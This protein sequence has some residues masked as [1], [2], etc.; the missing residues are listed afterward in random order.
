MAATASHADTVDARCELVPQG[1]KIAKQITSC[2][3]SQR[4]GYISLQ[5]PQGTRYDFSPQ[6]RPGRYSDQ[7]GELVVRQSG[8]GQR[9]MLFRMKAHM[10]Y[11]YWTTAAKMLLTPPEATA[12]FAEQFSWGSIRFQVES[13]NTPG[14][15]KVVITPSGLA[16]DNRPVEAEILGQLVRGDVADT[17]RDGSP[18]LYLYIRSNDTP[19]QMQL[20]A[21]SVNHGKSMSDIVLPGLNGKPE[22]AR[23]YR[24]WDQFSVVESSLVR[25]FPV[26]T[27][28]A[29]DSQPTSVRQIRYRLR[30]SEASWQLVEYTVDEF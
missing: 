25:R 20:L 28:M 18:E 16:I 11:V 13:A 23:G 2:T 22:Y 5:L 7:N 14:S 29:A 30:P 17:N 21:F 10:L 3:F 4:Q 24:G 9:G 6:S 1:S 8:M 26:F 27:E 12:P 15:N 19:P